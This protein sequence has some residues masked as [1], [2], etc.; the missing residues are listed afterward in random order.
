MSVGPRRAIAIVAPVAA[1]VGLACVSGVIFSLGWETARAGQQLET[2]G[3]TTTA[4]IAAKDERSVRGG[5]KAGQP[6]YRPDYFVTYRFTATDAA[7]Y[8][9]EVRVSPTFFF[10]AKVGGPTPVRYLPENPKRSEVEFGHTG[11]SSW[12]ALALGGSGVLLG[13]GL[14]GVAIFRPALLGI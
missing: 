5:V 9:S 3:V 11:A 8:F 2:L 14:A 12:S 6:E 7:A 10:A 13:I 1:G 4:T